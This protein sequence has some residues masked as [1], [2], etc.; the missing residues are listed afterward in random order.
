MVDDPAGAKGAWLG[1]VFLAGG[2]V[3]IYVGFVEL[4]RGPPLPD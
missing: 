1:G 3:V 4:F 2:V